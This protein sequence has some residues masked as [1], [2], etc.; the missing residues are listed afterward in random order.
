MFKALKKLFVA[1]VVIATT[2]AA[3]FAAVVAVFAWKKY[4]ATKDQSPKD[5]SITDIFEE[6]DFDLDDTV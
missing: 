4:K 1:F 3:A 5:E 6:E 2:V